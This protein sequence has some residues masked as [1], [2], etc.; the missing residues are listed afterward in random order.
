MKPEPD[1]AGL[2]LHVADIDRIALDVPAAVA[3]ALVA[4]ILT[5]TVAMS[6]GMAMLGEPTSLWLWRD[7]LGVVR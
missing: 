4:G 3:F 5:L 2:H 1:D 6:C 7:V